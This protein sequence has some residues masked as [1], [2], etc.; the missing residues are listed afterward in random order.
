MVLYKAVTSG[1]F[2]TIYRGDVILRNRYVL[3]SL[4]DGS[5]LKLFHIF[6]WEGVLIAQWSW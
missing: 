4:S 2:N 3:T 5:V 6:S 1:S